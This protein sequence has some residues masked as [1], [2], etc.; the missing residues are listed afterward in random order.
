MCCS[1]VFHKT[2][3]IRV[4]VGAIIGLVVAF[5][6]SYY[7]VKH[8]HDSGFVTEMFCQQNNLD[9]ETPDIVDDS[10][11]NACQSEIVLKYKPADLEPYL[12][13]MLR[14]HAFVGAFLAVTSLMVFAGLW[15]DK[16]RLIWPW[17]A[18]NCVWAISL[19]ITAILLSK[20]GFSMYVIIL[21]GL[22]AISV[23]TLLDAGHYS[24]KLTHLQGSYNVKLTSQQGTSNM[25][26]RP[27]LQQDFGDAQTSDNSGAVA[28]EAV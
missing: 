1:T 9:K 4:C 27:L 20:F 12:H 5:S 10:H 11:D 23:L 6:V 8:L 26:P 17:I 25:K 28:A 3:R 19:I 18:A 21:M 13:R 7:A 14:L 15:H 24:W 16:G 22:S 2:Q